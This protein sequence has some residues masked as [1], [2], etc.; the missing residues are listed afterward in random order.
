MADAGEVGGFG[1]EVAQQAVG[2]FVGAAFPRGVGVGEVDVKVQAVFELLEVGEF[3]AVVAGQRL[4]ELAGDRVERTDGCT[5][6]RV[7]ALIGQLSGRQESAPALDVRRQRAFAFRALHGVGLP[8]AESGAAIDHPRAFFDADSAG[9]MAAVFP[10]GAA[11]RS[12]R[13]A[14]ICLTFE[15]LICLAT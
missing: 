12:I 1:E 8:V 2:I 14:I 11:Y 6:E 5:A 10:T 13:S 4:A 3:F 15:A 9:D 7:G